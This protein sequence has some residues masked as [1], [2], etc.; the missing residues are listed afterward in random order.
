MARA[1]SLVA[2]SHVAG[3]AIVLPSWAGGELLPYE[4]DIRGE[5]RF[6]R[7]SGTYR[8]GKAYGGQGSRELVAGEEERRDAPSGG[9]VEGERWLGPLTGGGAGR[10]DGCPFVVPPRWVEAPARV[11]T[12]PAVQRESR[13][14]GFLVPLK[15]PGAEQMERKGAGSPG[16]HWGLP[17]AGPDERL[18]VHGRETVVSLARDRG[19]WG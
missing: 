9:R 11:G 17:V 1:G 16:R 13:D 5:L 14:A 3:C 4:L 19:R 10:S 6:A 7:W 18:V 15:A 12:V 2:A 8:T